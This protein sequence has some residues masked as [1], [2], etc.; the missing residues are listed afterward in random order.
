MVQNTKRSE[1]ET[2]CTHLCLTS[3]PNILSE[4]QQWKWNEN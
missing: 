3:V 1:S 2:D 4:W